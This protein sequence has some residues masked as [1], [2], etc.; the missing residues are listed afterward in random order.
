MNYL[1]RCPSCGKQ[2]EIQM[3]M[4]EYHADGHLCECGAELVRDLSDICTNYQINCTGFYSD[5]PS[6]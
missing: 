4:S 5:H 1:F 3:R 2:T 6:R